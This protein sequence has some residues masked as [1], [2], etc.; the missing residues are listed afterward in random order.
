[1]A[2][3]GKVSVPDST[4]AWAR[5][6]RN[7]PTIEEESPQFT[8]VGQERYLSVT[9]TTYNSGSGIT[10][11]EFLQLRVIWRHYEQT[12]DLGHM[13][14]DDS[15]LNK[16]YR[17]YVSPQN[18]HLAEKVYNSSKGYWK[19]YLD[20][21]AAG[22]ESLRPARDCR[23]WRAARYY[24][25]L[26]HRHTKLVDKVSDAQISRASKVWTCE[27]S[28]PSIH[29]ESLGTPAPAVGRS[30][31]VTNHAMG[32]GNQT[33]TPSADE[34]YPNTALLLLLQ[35][36][37]FSVGGLYSDMDWLAP[38]IPLKLTHT[39]RHPPR[40]GKNSTEHVELLQAQV[41]GYLCRRNTSGQMN[42]LPLAICEAKPFVRKSAVTSIRRQEGGEMACWINKCR[43]DTGLLRSSVS[44]RKRSVSPH[45]FW[46]SIHLSIPR[47]T[48]SLTIITM[49]RR[50]LISQDRHESTL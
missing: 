37:T 2:A 9:D 36:V 41:D 35:A 13:I 39:I 3:L 48:K 15:N 14:R 27:T 19:P 1:M 46:I 8:S 4:E 34:A 10:A 32:A 21:I 49:N 18:L 7:D 42:Q 30:P 17:G 44:G 40:F 25:V 24:Q 43:D 5:A 26:V 47:Y 31:F 20:D 45:P 16:P 22:K 11:S 6:V 50:L 33:N 12:N 28:R 23:D 38:R 29:N